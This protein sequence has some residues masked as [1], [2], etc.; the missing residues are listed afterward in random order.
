[1]ETKPQNE[2]HDTMSKP[3]T[4]QLSMNIDPELKTR[5]KIMAINKGIS[6][7]ELLTGYIIDGL[8]KDEKKE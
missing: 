3:G 1:M 4:I 7:T 6:M 2:I 8:K 5:A